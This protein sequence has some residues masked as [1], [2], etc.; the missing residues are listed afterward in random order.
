MND[1]YMNEKWESLQKEF[2][3]G[4]DV[5]VVSETELYLKD[6]NTSYRNHYYL[7][8]EES[9]RFHELAPDTLGCITYQ[10]SNGIG[11][12]AEY[13][14]HFSHQTG[15]EM[16]I[17]AVKEDAKLDFSCYFKEEN[18]IQETYVDEIKQAFIEAIRD[19]RSIRLPLLMGTKVEDVKG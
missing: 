12:N 6:R 2:K 18:R 17:I 15:K 1:V 13:Y 9:K 19:H 7:L 8:A 16:W 4:Y 14:L 5:S 11:I 10:P 3:R